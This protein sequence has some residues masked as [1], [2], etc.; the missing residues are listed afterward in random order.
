[1]VCKIQ[2]HNSR[3]RPEGKH[4]RWRTQNYSLALYSLGMGGRN[5]KRGFILS[6]MY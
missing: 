2:I 6:D 4:K 3:K 1:M 5:E